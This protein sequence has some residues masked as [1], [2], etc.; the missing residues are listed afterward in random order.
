MTTQSTLLCVKSLKS[1]LKIKRSKP[2]RHYSDW[3]ESETEE[4]QMES[5]GGRNL[6][7]IE[8]SSSFQVPQHYYIQS[9][10]PPEWFPCFRISDSLFFKRL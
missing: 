10:N 7:S 1:L 6:N 9:Q 4:R 2:E 8:L 5:T 3:I